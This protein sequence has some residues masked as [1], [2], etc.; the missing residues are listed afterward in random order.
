MDQLSLFGSAF[1][2]V[3]YADEKQRLSLLDELQKKRLSV[4]ITESDLKL[5][6]GASAGYSGNSLLVIDCSELRDLMSKSCYYYVSGLVA[7]VYS[8]EER[9]VY[10]QLKMVRQYLS[11]KP[12][13]RLIHIIEENVY[14]DSLNKVFTDLIDGPVMPINVICSKEGGQYV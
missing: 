10:D 2:M 8:G 6:E 3:V 12:F 5:N 1:E 4:L 7:I 11:N 14:F 9:D 13:I